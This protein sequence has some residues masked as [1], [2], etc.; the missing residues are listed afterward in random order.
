MVRI[1]K[2]PVYCFQLSCYDIIVYSLDKSLRR[3]C[4]ALKQ[5]K[6]INWN[7][8][9]ILPCTRIEFKEPLSVTKAGIT[10]P[11]A[12]DVPCYLWWMPRERALQFTWRYAFL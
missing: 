12:C 2:K 11:F 10:R 7:E 3:L 8:E 9:L 6:I 1:K 5:T 4:K